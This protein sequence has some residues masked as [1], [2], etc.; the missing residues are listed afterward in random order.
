MLTA[1]AFI[2]ILSVLI[3]VHELGHF[4][5]AKKF[6]IKVEEFGFGFPPK[7]FGIKRGET[8]YS[9]NLL[10]F[11]GFVKIFGEDGQEKQNKRSFGS[12]RIW[13]R[14]SVLLAGPAMNLLLAILLLSLGFM[15]G[16][17][18]SI[19]D[20]EGVSGAKVQITQIASNS[21][22]QAAGIKTGD[23][24]LGSSGLSGKIESL[25]KVGDLQN[26]IED[27]KGQEVLLNLKRGQDVLTIKLTP[28]INP[29]SDEGAMGVGLARVS[30]I[31]FPWYSAIWEG[32]KMAFNLT[33]LT[34]SSLFYLVWQ[35]FSSGHAG[36]SVTG[37]VGI[38]SIT[39]QA[40]Q[41]GFVYLLQLAALISINLGVINALPFPA[42][43]GGRVL[44]LIIEK[45]KRSPVSER[46]ER[47][48]HSAGF[49]FLILLMI[50]VS[51]RDIVKLF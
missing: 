39:G 30:S 44:F 33:W 2:I 12:K 29:P 47:T 51:F 43:D 11:G 26:F 21:P 32:A 19:E 4:L 28:R 41:M 31:S 49:I 38:Y 22:A 42:L 6:G 14:T 37:P 35:L 8:V 27:N 48:I 18:W 13:Q 9:L 25:D 3:F 40:A 36:E 10:P 20:S 15:I 45:I 17:P 5:T 34:I 1:I 7:I 46:V 24:V 16:L 50:A 23:V